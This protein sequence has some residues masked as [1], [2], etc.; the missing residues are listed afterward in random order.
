MTSRASH[1]F[2]SRPAELKKAHACWQKGLASANKL[3]WREA[4]RQFERACQAAPSDVLYRLNLARALFKQERFEEAARQAQL[5]I[6]IEPDNVLARSLAGESLV[7]TGANGA[8]VEVLLAGREQ[9]SQDFE[10]LFALGQALQGAGRYQEGISV[11]MEAIAL[12]VDHPQCFY[13]LAM[14][15]HGLHMRNEAV[16][17]LETVQVLGIERGEMACD[18]L[19]AFI[20]RECLDWPKAASDLASFERRVREAGDDAMQW[21]SVF[22]AVV[23]SDDPAFQ[24]KAA[25]ICSRHIQAQ[26]KPMQPKLL[27]T[28][29]RKLRLGFVSADF[30]QHATT[31]LLAEVLERL[32]RD[33]FDL[34]LYSHGPDDGSAMR[35]RIQHAAHSFMEVGK[36]SDHEAALR[37]AADHIDV[38][39][40]LKGHTS[41]SRLGIFAW[42]P[43]PVQATYLG[44]PA[45][46]GAS[47]MDYFIGDEVSSPLAHAG[48]FTEQLALMPVCYQPNDRQRP[49][50]QATTRAEHGLPAD[51]LVLCGF[52]Q[53]FKISPEV[54]DSWCSLMHRLPGSVLWLLRWTAESEPRLL[55]EA[56]RRGIGADRIVFAPAVH[57]SQH[58]S[59]FAL[60]DIYL[61]AWPCNGH[62]T[63]SDA[64]W[65]GVPVVTLQ[66]RTFVSRVASS[67]LQA[68][69]LPEGVT[70]DVHTYEAQALKLAADPALRQQWRER[71]VAARDTAPLF[72][73]ARYAADFGHL[74]EG[75]VARAA[76]GL[77]PEH[78]T[79]DVALKG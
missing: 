7:K 1:H 47:F 27:P 30:H 20:R 14:C 22:G 2:G 18:S 3:E 49:L 63:V 42:R 21:M 56:A 72:D 67:L 52:N 24:L 29:G 34:Y 13:H 4:S 12:K 36:L 16:E 26:A 31:I 46:T 57:N 51:G 71:L 9:A 75:M 65:A 39:V 32:D 61:D 59:R 48:D 11:F 45:S 58:I 64:L 38:L 60:A 5:V 53:P 79:A 37:I 70:T 28:A 77:P 40:D 41:N 8:A 68:V 66:G 35:Q 19:L 76:Q 6:E 15:F 73:A 50:P 69:G 54:L 25:R 44:F 55:A 62:T 17:C 74:I 10:Y 78:L 33:R 43:A 23:L